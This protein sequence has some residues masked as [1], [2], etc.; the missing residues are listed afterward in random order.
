MCYHLCC[1]SCYYLLSCIKIG[2]KLLVRHI[3]WIL[4]LLPSCPNNLQLP[5]GPTSILPSKKLRVLDYFCSSSTYFLL[6]EP[7]KTSVTSCC[8]T[9]INSSWPEKS[10]EFRLKT[11]HC[12]GIF[13]W[14]P[15][16]SSRI[17]LLLLLSS[18]E[19]RYIFSSNLLF[20][21]FLSTISHVSLTH[22][23]RSFF[24]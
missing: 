16:N 21:S 22:F 4:L 12:P 7:I 8:T 2:V 10:Y 23:V 3:K 20:S 14:P 5:T 19:K 18:R 1:T 11:T 6:A 24:L 9:Q 13:Y 15:I 17:V